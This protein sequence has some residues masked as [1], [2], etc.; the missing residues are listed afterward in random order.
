MTEILR[1]ATVSILPNM[2]KIFERCIVRQLYSFVLEF[3]SKY[4]CS[5][6][7][8]Y[9]TQVEEAKSLG[10]LLTDLS[11]AFDCLCHELLLAKL[12]AYWFSI[13][14]LRL[15][16]SYLSN[17]KQRTKVN[18]LHSPWEKMLFGV[19][20]G[21]IVGPLLLNNLPVWLCKLCRW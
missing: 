16:H 20:Q 15:I 14:A 6:R 8:G 13:A 11:K 10:A 9:S 19:Q 5:F 12:H 18:I 7:K 17:R 1:V 3:L 2:F 4:Q 21:S